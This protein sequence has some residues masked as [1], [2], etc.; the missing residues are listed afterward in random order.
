MLTQPPPGWT[1]LQAR[2]QSAPTCE[3]PLIFNEMKSLLPG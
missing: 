2:A 3:L 1:I